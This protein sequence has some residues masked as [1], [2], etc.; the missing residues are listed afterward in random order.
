M[1]ALSK[2][3]E[4]LLEMRAKLTSSQTL[5]NQAGHIRGLGC[6]KA[7]GPSPGSMLMGAQNTVTLL[8]FSKSPFMG[9]LN[10]VPGGTIKGTS[11]CSRLASFPLKGRLDSSTTLNLG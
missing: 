11:A 2:V 5:I 10:Q 1:L 8:S 4:L 9:I 3:A 6:L 7:Y